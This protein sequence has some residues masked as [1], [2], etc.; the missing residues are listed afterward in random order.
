MLVN[1]PNTSML[2]TNM[3]DEAWEIFDIAAIQAELDGNAIQYR[4]FLKVPR[5]SC[6]LYFLP[7]ESEDTQSPHTEDE[8]YYVLKG[9]AHL[10]VGDAT[11]E[12]GAGS[13]LYV[14]ASET[15]SFFN[16][17][18]DITLLVFFAASGR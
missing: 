2:M 15:H 11:R 1:M 8:V 12:I 10:K 7:R 17:E 16:I 13:L 3:R 4:E 5:L 9:K 14:K 18:E 6:G